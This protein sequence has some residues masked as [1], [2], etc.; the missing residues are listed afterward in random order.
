M[1]LFSPFKTF[2]SGSL[3][4][5]HTLENKVRR[6]VVIRIIATGKNPESDERREGNGE[7]N[8]HLSVQ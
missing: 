6:F 5:Q 8:E 1:F 2:S 4:E 7:S 3:M